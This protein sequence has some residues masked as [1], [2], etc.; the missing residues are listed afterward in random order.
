MRTDPTTLDDLKQKRKIDRMLRKFAEAYCNGMSEEEMVA[1]FDFDSP[2]G[3]EIL[4]KRLGIPKRLRREAKRRGYTK[5]ES[6]GLPP[7][8]LHNYLTKFAKGVN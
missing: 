2:D 7:A 4:A 5:F 6:L 1:K 3:P 8:L